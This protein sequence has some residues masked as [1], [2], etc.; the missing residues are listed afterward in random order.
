MRD[1]VRS[2]RELP[3]GALALEPPRSLFA[4]RVLDRGLRERLA[5]MEERVHDLLL[6]S[7][8]GLDDGAIADVDM[9]CAAIDEQRALLVDV[10]RSVADETARRAARR[11]GPRHWA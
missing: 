1:H 10:Q 6:G 11:L 4:L 2:V 8:E 9:L 7:R 3:S 5:V